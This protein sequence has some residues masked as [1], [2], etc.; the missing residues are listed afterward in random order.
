MRQK[1]PLRVFDTPGSTSNG[2]I[3]RP[4]SLCSCPST[5]SCETLTPPGSRF[6]FTLPPRLQML[7]RRSVSVSICRSGPWFKVRSCLPG[8]GLTGSQRG[9]FFRPRRWLVGRSAVL[10]SSLTRWGELTCAVLPSN[11][12][13]PTFAEV[14]AMSIRLVWMLASSSQC[15]RRAIAD[16][17]LELSFDPSRTGSHPNPGKVRWKGFAEGFRWK[18]LR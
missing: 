6:T 3:Y 10:M 7:S 13:A 1:F 2:Y 11:D 4:L 15:G 17:C 12:E 8:L 14:R 9:G 16:R 5:G 18:F